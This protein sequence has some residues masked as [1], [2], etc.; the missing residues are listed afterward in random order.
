VNGYK[1]DEDK[2]KICRKIVHNES[3]GEE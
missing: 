2:P 3:K 1:N